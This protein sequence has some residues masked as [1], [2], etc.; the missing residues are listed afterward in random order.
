MTE[1]T[2]DLRELQ[3][4]ED[5]IKTDAPRD[6]TTNNSN[7]LQEKLFSRRQL[8][9]V[10]RRLTGFKRKVLEHEYSPERTE[11]DNRSAGGGGR[12]LFKTFIAFVI[13]PSFL[14]LFYYL[15]LASDVYVAEAKL[16]VRAVAKSGGG[17]TSS[18]SG[19]VGALMSKI[20]LGQ[21]GS[22]AQDTRI[23][24]D[25]LKSRASMEDVGGREELAKY[26]DRDDIDWASRL[27]ATWRAEELLDYWRKKV[28][29]SI[30]T[31]SN[32]L[33]LRVKAFSPDDALTLAQKLAKSSEELINQLSRRSREDALRR[34]EDEVS[35]GM[36]EL[37][38]A[39]L[40]LLTFQQN[41]QSIDPIESAKQI[42]TLLSNLRLQEI[43]LESQLA[44][45]ESTG[46]AGRPGD[47]YI[48]SQLDVVKKQIADFENLLTGKED[49]SVSMQL[50]DFE[51]LKLK[52]EFAEQ[53]YTLAR[54]SYEDARR[55]VTKQQ[56]YLV[57]VVPPFKPEHALFPRAGFDTGLVFAGCFIFWA[58][59]AL[60]VASVKDSMD[61]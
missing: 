33:T 18:S 58:I 40:Q 46:V 26:Y 30:D 54:A 1:K 14:A 36:T 2:T 9:S 13:F 47:R 48:Q 61:G 41:N 53:V 5:R 20:G 29:A 38:D 50:R 32:I 34:A 55:E 7:A 52:Q 19:A 28:T 57:V 37:A 6:E 15:T 12:F 35:R 44:V 27:D 56:L 42:T 25:Y 8:Q 49:K 51:L 22:T 3:H 10:A 59:G 31:I 23:V 45:G 60:L 4:D 21:A 16:T 39:R 11:T 17:S 43:Q 24:L